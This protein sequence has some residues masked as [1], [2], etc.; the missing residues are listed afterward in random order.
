MAAAHRYQLLTALLLPYYPRVTICYHFVTALLQL[1]YCLATTLL[2]LCFHPATTLLLSRYLLLPPCH[3][4]VTVLLSPCYHIVTAML[5]PCSSTPPVIGRSHHELQ[6]TQAFVCMQTD[7]GHPP[8][9]QQKHVS[10]LHR[11]E[12]KRKDYTFWHQ[13]NEKPSIILGCPGSRLHT[14]TRSLPCHT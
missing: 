6:I 2:P 8:Q 9:A 10:R 7:A 12:K 4:F 11:K 5:L 13:F 3:H 1:C 14:H